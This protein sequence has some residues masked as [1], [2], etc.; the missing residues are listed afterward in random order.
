[1]IIAVITGSSILRH[2]VG[3]RKFRG[4]VDFHD[5]PGRGRDAVAHAGRRGDE[6]DV[7]FALEALLRDLHVQQAEKAAAETESERHGIFRLVEK[8]RVI[9]LQFA[10]RVAQIFVI[11]GAAP[12]TGPQT[13]WA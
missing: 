6:V 9:E 2:F 8:R 7:E 1:M 5:V 4:A 12:E 10:E 13:P 11:A 3:R